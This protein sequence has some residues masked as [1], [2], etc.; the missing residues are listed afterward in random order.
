MHPRQMSAKERL[1]LGSVLV[2]FGI[3]LYL[4][5]SYYWQDKVYDE[6]FAWRMFSP[7]RMTSCDFRLWHGEART[8]IKLSK[9]YHVV[10]INLAKRARMSVV[11]AII[12]DR[13]ESH[14][15]VSGQLRCTSP[16]AAA[17]GLCRNRQDANRDG[18]P[19]GYDDG[20]GCAEEPMQCF[21]R[22]CPDLDTSACAARLCT[23]DLLPLNTN[24]CGEVIR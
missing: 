12:N 13:C 2:F 15:F 14:S 21:Q 18:I 3:Q 7:V 24:L 9:N 19:D 17:I 22:D 6:R 16:Q 5:L 20:V 10:W 23:T 11:N 8:R 1:L 4:P